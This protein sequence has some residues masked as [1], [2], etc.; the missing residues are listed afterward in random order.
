MEDPTAD[1]LAREAAALGGDLA[2]VTAAAGAGSP[3]GPLA[4]AAS[5]SL[6]DFE[7]VEHSPSASTAFAAAGSPHFPQQSDPVSLVSPPPPP[8]GLDAFQTNFPP[9][10]DQIGQAPQITKAGP[11]SPI[12][13]PTPES[14]EDIHAVREWR[15]RY[16]EAIAER[17][18][19][20]E[21]QH[22]EQVDA[23]RQAIDRFYEEYNKQKERTHSTNREAETQQ[24]AENASGSIWEKVTR[25]VEAAAQAQS[26]GAVAKGPSRERFRCLLSDLRKDARAPGLAA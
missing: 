12:H 11:T 3:E 16:A 21:Q 19:R 18:R 8:G 13:S 5:C 14:E 25:E 23:A 20:S 22:R 15:Q 26:K 1:F 7:K 9:V 2:A 17:D 10:A 24:A 6:D 4:A